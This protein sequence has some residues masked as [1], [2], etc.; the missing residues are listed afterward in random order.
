M[1]EESF[2]NGRINGLSQDY[3]ENGKLRGEIIYKKGRIVKDREYID[4]EPI[5]E[6]R[7]Y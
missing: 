7:I 5:G 6:W 1:A 3:S 2:K 4:G